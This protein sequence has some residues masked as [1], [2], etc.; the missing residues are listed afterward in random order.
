MKISKNILL[1]IISILFLLIC[2]LSYF[3]YA[4][5]K[6]L[7]NYI[8]NKVGIDNFNLQQKIAQTIEQY[9]DFLSQTKTTYK[10]PEEEEKIINSFITDLENVDEEDLK[11]EKEIQQGCRLS[12]IEEEV[13]DIIT[14]D[15]IITTEKE[16][17]ENPIKLPTFDMDYFS[18][19]SDDS[20]TEDISSEIEDTLEDIELPTLDDSDN[21]EDIELPTLDD[22]D[23][24]EEDIEL[25]TLDDS[26]DEE[27]IELLTLDD[28]DD[29][30][31]IEEFE[32]PSID[33]L[34]ESADEIALS[35]EELV[36]EPEVEFKI[37]EVVEEQVKE[38]SMT[39]RCEYVLPRGKNKGKC[40][41]GKARKQGRCKKH[42]GK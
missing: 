5:Y 34:I 14:E 3:F 42:T 6:Y 24:E 10:N 22:S 28:S 27:D 2:G 19:M 37:V 4:K 20:E 21:E 35:C 23:D 15:I 26:D 8:N 1:L 13:D 29:E 40:C 7:I 38:K 18:Q 33:D 41:G 32:L 9:R 36:E 16:A 17:L 31:D 39:P 25:P 11:L 12:T 30:E